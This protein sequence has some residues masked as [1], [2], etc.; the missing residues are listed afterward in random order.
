MARPSNSPTC[1]A[2]MSSMLGAQTHRSAVVFNSDRRSAI[3]YII[4]G[5]GIHHRIKPL[6]HFRQL[7]FSQRSGVGD[8]LAV[9]PIG[10][11]KSRKTECNRRTGL[12]FT[13]RYNHVLKKE[14][15]YKLDKLSHA[16]LETCH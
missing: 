2:R 9:H 1:I 15:R 12:L 11:K 13:F 4:S 16:I 3:G 8:L 10:K 7:L 14:G 6:H 5:L